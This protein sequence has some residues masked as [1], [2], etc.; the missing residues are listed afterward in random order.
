MEFGMGGTASG[1]HRQVTK[2]EMWRSSEEPAAAFAMSMSMGANQLIQPKDMNISTFTSGGEGCDEEFAIRLP[3]ERIAQANSTRRVRSPRTRWCRTILPTR[4]SNSPRVNVTPAP[5]ATRST[6][7]YS[8]RSRLHPPY[9][10]S[11]ITCTGTGMV[12][13]FSLFPRTMRFCSAEVY[14]LSARVQSPITRAPSTIERLARQEVE[15]GALA[16]VSGCDSNTRPSKNT[17]SWMC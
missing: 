6:L 17:R 13:T 12:S 14:W 8:P 10:P 9:G 2:M 1:S 5:P 4:S 11:I 7:S 15:A 16:M 3:K